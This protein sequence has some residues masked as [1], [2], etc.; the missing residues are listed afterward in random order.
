MD[1]LPYPQDAAL[2]AHHGGDDTPELQAMK[3]VMKI[4]DAVDWC[5]FSITVRNTYGIPFQVTFRRHQAGT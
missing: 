1:I 3:S 2:V 4:P 5:L